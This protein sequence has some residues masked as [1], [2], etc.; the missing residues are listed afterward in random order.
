MI[1]A[2]AADIVAAADRTCTITVTYVT[3]VVKSAHA[4]DIVIA[5]YRTCTITVTYGTISISA[6]AADI[7]LSVE[8]RIHNAHIGNLAAIAYIS[9]ESDIVCR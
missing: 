8:I 7:V 5:T 2:H 3:V 1:P 4:S 9:E 6:H